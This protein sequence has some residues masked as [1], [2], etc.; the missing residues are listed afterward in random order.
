MTL[1]ARR[2]SWTQKVRIGGQTLHLTV[3]EYPDGRPGEVFLNVS[4]TGSFNR[5]VMET[6]AM[7]ISKALQTGVPVEEVVK[8]N[9]GLDFPPNGAVEGSAF[10]REATSV[11]DWVAQELEAA[12]CRRAAPGGR[13]SGV[14]FGE[15]G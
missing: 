1:P 14:A 10:V 12:Y 6:L 15:G 2:K 4:K 5:G 8:A 9:R 11:P 13:S 7:N 3:G